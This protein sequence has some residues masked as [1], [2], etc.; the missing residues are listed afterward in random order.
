MAMNLPLRWNDG[1]KQRRAAQIPMESWKLHRSTIE[2]LYKNETLADLVETMKTNHSFDATERQYTHRLR[3]WG[4]YKR[5]KQK[6]QD[7]DF[8]LE[9]AS[10]LGQEKCD[11]SIPISCDKKSESLKR[12]NS[13]QNTGSRSSQYSLDSTPASKRLKTL[14]EEHSDSVSS[15]SN[16]EN[17][18]EPSY[19]TSYEESRSIVSSIA[20][21]E[22]MLAEGSSQN[23]SGSQNISSSQSS[24]ITENEEESKPAGEIESSAR[25][26]SQFEDPWS[27]RRLRSYVAQ[28]TGRQPMSL[29]LEQLNRL[30]HGYSVQYSNLAFCLDLAQNLEGFDTLSDSFYL[31]SQAEEGL[32]VVADY[33]FV[34]DQFE[35]ASNIYS[36]LLVAEESETHSRTRSHTEVLLLTPRVV[37]AFR[38]ARTVPQCQLVQDVLLKRIKSNEN[39]DVSISEL[40]IVHSFLADCFRKQGQFSDRLNHLVQSWTIAHRLNEEGDSRLAPDHSLLLYLYYKS[41]FPELPSSNFLNVAD[42]T[43]IPSRPQRLGAYGAT[44]IGYDDFMAF[45]AL[46]KNLGQEEEAIRRDNGAADRRILRCVRDCVVWCGS[47]ERGTRKETSLSKRFENVLDAWKGDTTVS[48]DQPYGGTVPEIEFGISTAENLHVCD[49]ISSCIGDMKGLSAI[50][51]QKLVDLHF[52]FLFKRVSTNLGRQHSQVISNSSSRLSI[53]SAIAPSIGSSNASFRNF[54]DVSHSMKKRVTGAPSTR[55]RESSSNMSHLS[56]MS[57]VTDLFGAS[58]IHEQDETGT[59]ILHIKQVTWL[60]PNAEECRGL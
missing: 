8:V 38:S 1:G 22:V 33:L 20:S 25:R 45:C 54:R 34:V 11:E 23:V 16:E 18:L 35:A 19:I 24:S 50:S 53:A 3:Q 2:E 55:S 13:R 46:V 26:H 37:A 59:A 32:K 56:K 47:I 51:Y 14:S 6:E 40:F 12:P 52:E 7:I 36:V 57:H 21:H 10:G 42:L 29:A 15:S 31:P 4:I 58:S 5:E 30:R 48:S 41:A 39:R 9:S 60:E 43:D 17:F 27:A 44:S 28:L 49:Q